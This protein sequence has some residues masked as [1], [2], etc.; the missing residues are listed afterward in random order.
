MAKSNLRNEQKIKSALK[1]CGAGQDEIAG[2]SRNTR[3]TK[4]IGDEGV[5]VLDFLEKAGIPIECYLRG[6]DVS[7]EGWKRIR[8]S[9]EL[10]GNPGRVDELLQYRKNYCEI[11][12]ALNLGDIDDLMNYEA[13]K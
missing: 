6:G 5:F 1:E 12:S 9:A 8:E 3:V 7:D 13:R 10:S 2:A 4:L 11:C